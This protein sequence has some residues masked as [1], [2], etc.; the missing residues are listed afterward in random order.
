[1]PEI[2]I[3]ISKSLE[4]NA[5][6]CFEKSKKAKRKLASL[7]AAME[8]TREKIKAL[9]KEAPERKDLRK[10][11]KRDWFEKF[12][13]FFTSDNL[14]A[15]AGKDAKSNEE[16]VKKYM[17]EKDLYF[18]ADIDG[19]PHVVL[20]TE[21]SKAPEKSNKEAAIFA[22]DFSKAWQS[23]TSTGVVYSVLPIQVSKSAPSGESL[24]TGAFVISGKRNWFRKTPLDLSIGVE[25]SGEGHRVISG[26]TAAVK[27]H[28]EFSV[29]LEQGSLKKGEAAKKLFSLFEKR[30]G[31][32]CVSLDEVVS[33]L[34]SGGFEIKQ[35][36]IL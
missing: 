33:M 27:K 4:E 21:G 24:G 30:F 6:D 16:V 22:L 23:G 3:D 9:G 1:M 26:P 14:L 10:K 2:E 28:A 11:R 31:K 20:L 25:K 35:G 19:A 18:H 36:K 7:K 29:Q 5:S 8:R 32:N 13:W 15:I 34:P 17:N 12:R